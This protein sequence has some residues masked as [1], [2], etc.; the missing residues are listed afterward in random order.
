MQHTHRRISSSCLLVACFPIR[1][2]PSL[3]DIA[4]RRRFH[5]RI[6]I[7]YDVARSATDYLRRLGA[8]EPQEANLGHV[9]RLVLSV[10]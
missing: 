9:Y 7:N 3:G 6:L 2:K 8:L 1:M 5:P 10:S 4:M